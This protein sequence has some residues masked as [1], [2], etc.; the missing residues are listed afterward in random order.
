MKSQEEILDSVDINQ[1]PLF[2]K[3]APH[4]VPDIEL[5]DVLNRLEDFP[6]IID[7][8]SEDEF[9][10]SHLPHA[11]NFPIL[12]N[13]ERR[14]IGILYKYKG[15][16]TATA[17]ALEFANPKLASLKQLLDKDNHKNPLIYCWRGGGRSRYT[18]NEL[19]KMGYNAIKLKN[20]HKAWR[21]VVHKALY[22]E[23]VP[24][25]LVLKGLTGVGK[26][27]L[28]RAIQDKYR[29]LDLEY[30]ARNAA[31]SF[32]R[33]PFQITNDYHFVSQK[34]FEEQ[35]YQELYLNKTPIS[36]YGVLA[37][38]ES[39]RIGHLFLSNPLFER[40]KSSK[41]ILI[42]CSIEK[43]VERTYKDYIGEKQEGLQLLFDDM[44][45][46]KKYMS[47]NQ[48]NH[49]LSLY[50]SNDIHELLRIL[51]VDY[52]DPKYSGIYPKE[53]LTID[54]TDMDAAIESLLTHL[55][56]NSTI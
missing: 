44:Q 45:K 15:K 46:I 52:Y 53:D 40:L 12:N 20:G 43:R 33:I 18:T 32:G 14:E 48:F 55:Q 36:K 41:T 28:L 54:S 51:L 1:I 27:E 37:E 11:I 2:H 22:N 21:K 38:S 5:Q 19:I 35:I 6:L 13:E 34:S 7:V 9:K 25:F 23:E 49:L 3:V 8:R 16:E 30:Y 42:T 10:V 39:R 29:F 47:N 24:S 4:D 17:K 31:S 50:E 56:E 26:T